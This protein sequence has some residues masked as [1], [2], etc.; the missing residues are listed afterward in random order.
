MIMKIVTSHEMAEIDKLTID[1]YGIPS[2][3][4]MERAALSIVKHVLKF[5]PE[6]LIILAGP[7]NNGG[8]GIAC[9]RILKNKVKNIKIFQLFP[10]EKLSEDCKLQLSVAKK[11]GIPIV[12]GY[13]DND[14]IDKADLIIDAIFGT[15]LKREIEGKVAEFIE[16]LNSF[17]KLTVAVDI[18]SGVSSDTGEILGAAI[19]ANLTVTFGLPKRGHLLYP[20]KDYTGE[21]FIEDIGFPEEL[22]NN[23]NLK[24]SLIEREFALSLMPP[25]PKYSHKTRY[26]HVFVIAGS[27][28]KTGAAMMTAKAALRAGSGL[29]TMAVPAALKVVFQSKVLEEMILPLPCTM[30]TLSKQALPEIMDFVKEKANSIAFGPGVGVNEDIEIILRELILNSSCPIVIDA[31]GL[32]V[33]SKILNVLKDAHSEIVLTPHP[34]E[35]SR[36]INIPVKD[37]EKQRIDI[38]QKVAQELNVI[39]VL[40]G[41]PTVIAEPQGRVY[42]NTTGNPG[43]AT[44]GSGD[45]LTGIIAS[46]IGQGLS[47]LYA[48]VF[49]VYIHGLSGDIA[50]R[51][52]GFHGLIAGDIIETLPEAFI[53]LTDEIDS[54]P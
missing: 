5:N 6:N 11:F 44:G 37:I 3:V 41:V 18:P 10:E 20:G 31:D 29:V 36:L 14:Q 21:L 40:K 49:G 13:P 45:V 42:L 23:E 4:L 33:L 34:G 22:T 17:K 8:D 53:E 54:E 52:K 26:G 35:L 9:G 1:Y 25:R 32:T 28:G 39:I 15:G 24:I 7:G 50:S 47:P 38:A 30:N 48:S 16:I 51:R 46:L 12:V 27:T 19:K 2:T 43:M